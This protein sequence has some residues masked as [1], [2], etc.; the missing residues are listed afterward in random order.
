MLSY[1][2]MSKHSRVWI[3]Q[4]NREFNEREVKEINFLAEHFADSWSSH[5]ADLKAHISVFHQRFIVVMVDEQ[6][7]GASGCSIDKSFGFIRDLQK[8]YS[9]DLL[10]R[11]TVAYWDEDGR[12]QTCRLDEITKL[13]EHSLINEDTIVFNNLVK[14]KAELE[15]NWQILLRNSWILQ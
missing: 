10:N 11:M 14:D 4:S 7:A 13:L 1:E 2:E 9:I 12:V 5:G 6:Q 15:S 3:Y 8:R